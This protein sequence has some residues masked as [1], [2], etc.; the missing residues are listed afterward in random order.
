[1]LWFLILAIILI[2]MTCSL[3]MPGSR[4]GLRF[5]LHPDFS[6]VTASVVLSAMGQAFFSLSV[7]IGCL[8][9]YAS[10]FQRDVPLVSSAFSVCFI[11]TLVAILSGF[12]IFPAVFSVSGV[13]VDAGPG[14]VFITLPN[15]FNM[16][17]GDVPVVGYLFSGLFYILLLLAALTSSISMHEID[18]AFLHEKFHLSRPHAASVVTAV[19]LV[20][21]A[22][23]S[24]SFGSWEDVRIFGMGF[25]ELFDFLTAKFIMPLCSIFISIFVGWVLDRKLVRSELT[26]DNTL[27]IRAARFFV[28]LIR[29]VAP[30]GMS[31]IFLNELLS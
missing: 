5:L 21:G 8:A 25:F 16:A 9:T 13:E 31:I 2:L 3:S 17:F 14:L 24:L 26:N 28:F 20:L 18:T 23:C 30:F 19:C 15:V 29:W 6:K 22:A 7:G 12:I 1:M 4:E 27:H 11:D 10:Y